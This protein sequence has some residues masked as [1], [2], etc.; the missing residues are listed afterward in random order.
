MGPTTHLL[1]SGVQQGYPLDPLLFSLVLQQEMIS[2]L[3]LN[4]V[5][6][7]WLIKELSPAMG[8]HVNMAKCELFRQLTSEAG[9]QQGDPLGPLFFALVLHKVIDTIDAD[10]DCLHLILQA[11]Y[12][13]DGVLAGPRQAVLRALSIIED[14]GPPLGIFINLSKCQL[15]SRSDISMF[16][17]VMKASHVPH[18]DILGTPIGDYLFCTGFFAAKRAELTKLLSMLEDV[19]VIDPQVAFNLLRLCSG[20]CKMVH[21]ARSTPPSVAADS[22]KILDL[23]LRSCF[24]KCLSLDLTE[25][26]WCQSQL[27]LSSLYDSASPANK[28]RLLSASASL[29]TSWVSVLPSDEVVMWFSDTTMQLRDVFV[30]ICHKANLGVRIEAGSALTPDLSR[31]RPAD[32]LVNNWIG[33]SS[34]VFDALLAEPRKHQE[35]DPKC[36]TLG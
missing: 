5:L 31:S 12:L 34:A 4:Y 21:L 32:A 2:C 22:L 19:S 11:W 15:F 20:F 1:S 7:I 10:D 35:N 8:L 36:D 33:G 13:D 9:V 27:S 6:C 26:A 24:S 30:D 3:H 17:P 29:A 23:D 16:P 28:A 25:A 14:L 18:L